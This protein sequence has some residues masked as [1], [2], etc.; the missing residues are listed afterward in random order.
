M[1]K[2]HVNKG[3]ILL[4]LACLV[5]S[6]VL[7]VQPIHAE[8]RIIIVPDNYQ[9][10][11]DA[12]NAAVSGDEVYVRNGTYNET[13]AIDKALTLRGE[14]AVNTIIN[15]GNHGTV[16]LIRHDNVTFTGFTVKYDQTPNSP[17]SLW[18]WSTRLGGI[19]VNSANYCNIS[20]NNVQDCGG[21]IWLYNSK[22]CTVSDN[23]VF[24]NDYGIRVETSSGN[25]LSGNSVNGNWGGLWLLSSTNNKFTGN[26]MTGNTQNFG[27]SASHQSQY[28]NDLDSSNTVEGKPIYYWIDASNTVVPSDAGCVVLVDCTDVAVQGLHLSKLKCAITLVGTRSAQITGNTIA[29]CGSG[30]ETYRTIGGEI[31]GNH[32]T[33]SFGI[34][35]GGDGTRITRNTVTATTLGIGNSGA[36][37]TIAENI[38][39]LSENGNGYALN[40]SG[41]YTNITKNTLNGGSYVYAVMDGSDNVFIRNTMNNN[42]G[43]RAAGDRNIVAE[44]TVS[45]AGG[46]SVSGSNCTICK[47]R[48]TNGFSLTVGGHGNLYYANQVEGCNTGAE[49]GGLEGFSSGNTIFLNN[50]VHNDEQIYN[51]GA[52][53][54]NSWDNGAEG[55]YWSDYTGT[56]ANGDGFGDTP[57]NIMG[58]KLDTQSHG[59]VSVVTGQDHYP[60]M[61]P[62]NINSAEVALPELVYVEP[63]PTNTPT[64]TQTPTPTLAATSSP[65]ST[66]VPTTSP[67][68]AS[69]T[70]SPSQTPSLA[71]A[72]AQP[73]PKMFPTEIIYPIA[74]IGAAVVVLAVAVVLW[75]RKQK[76][77]T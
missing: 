48:I 56:D 67:T 38:I 40:C 32:I 69:P 77:R 23:T 55:N 19:H 28:V 71:P 30:I 59:L 68:E 73:Q 24:R 74:G 31:S 10:I 57:Y 35:A 70:A 5:A 18:M 37:Q 12:V 3:I 9:T 63:E 7:A 16:V 21:G 52:N 27:I 11:T 66:S 64:P 45:G 34:S 47:N 76:K 43:L 1:F 51:L 65:T 14:N 75:R 42:Y 36:Y 25:T 61:A 20:G 15:G 17:K 50:F 33:A 54:A 41:A 29:D 46:I 72:D 6:S 62:F 44:N 4:V 8:P 2:V 13:F 26:Q 53:S 60:L 22:D 58:E 39:T 49:P